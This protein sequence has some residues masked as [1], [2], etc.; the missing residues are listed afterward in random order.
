MDIG[1]GLMDGLKFAFKAALVGGL[2]LT[3][4]GIGG[5]YIAYEKGKEAGK[6]ENCTQTQPAPKAPGQ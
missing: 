6:V 1:K 2:V 5:A 3:A 4:G